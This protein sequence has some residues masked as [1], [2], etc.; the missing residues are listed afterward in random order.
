MTV[1][2][3][4]TL[5]N[6]FSENLLSNELLYHYRNRTYFIF[7][8]NLNIGYNVLYLRIIAKI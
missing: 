8:I 4:K 2:T 3:Q 6:L 7:L 1:N 5:K